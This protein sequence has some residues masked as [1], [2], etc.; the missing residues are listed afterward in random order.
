MSRVTYECSGR[1]RFS[2]DAII[3]TS[4]RSCAVDVRIQPGAHDH[5]FSADALSS[6]QLA[7][8][9]QRQVADPM[10]PLR[11]GGAAWFSFVMNVI[12]TSASSTS[13]ASPERSRK[14]SAAFGAPLPD[15]H[16]GAP[17]FFAVPADFGAVEGG[18]AYIAPALGDAA[19]Y[20]TPEMARYGTHSALLAGFGAPAM[21]CHSIGMP[22]FQMG[23]VPAWFADEGLAGDVGNAN[24]SGVGGA[25]GTVGME[26]ALDGLLAE[27]ALDLVAEE[28]LDG[29]LAEEAL[30]G[31]RRL[32]HKPLLV[33]RW[34]ATSTHPLNLC[35][36]LHQHGG[37]SRKGSGASSSGCSALHRSKSM[38]ELLQIAH[39]YRFSKVSYFCHFKENFDIYI[40]INIYIHICM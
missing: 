14:L 27:E 16:F 33:S 1:E 29:L 20:G 39:R 31:L 4:A 8:E 22:G 15:A 12:I 10:S 19:V 25:Q 2:I 7:Q 6:S 28:A 30:D 18:V 24:T 37:A 11:S 5:V 9:V 26:E 34:L 35:C 36:S 32:Q 3:E 21:M 38:P 40:Y 13:A 23:G 17:L